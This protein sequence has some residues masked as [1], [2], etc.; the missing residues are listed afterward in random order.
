ML[1]YLYI[2]HWKCTTADK[3]SSKW[4]FSNEDKISINNLQ[5][6][7]GYTCWPFS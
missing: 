3:F 1:N 6:L 2:P 5:Q 4:F 7:K